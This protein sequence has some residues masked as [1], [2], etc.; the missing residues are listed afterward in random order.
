[1][2]VV[3]REE[4]VQKDPEMSNA[5]KEY[6][7]I[8]LSDGQSHSGFVSMAGARQYAREEMLDSWEIYYG[9]RLV[10]RHCLIGSAE[11]STKQQ[12]S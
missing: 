4:F 3:W 12:G 9:N 11:N 10:E 1:M 7:L 8:S 6:H 5:P 2:F